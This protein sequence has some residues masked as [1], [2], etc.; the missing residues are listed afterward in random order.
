MDRIISLFDLIIATAVLVVVLVSSWVAM[1]LKVNTNK[2]RIRA[3]EQRVDAACND[4]D[5]IRVEVDRKAD[6]ILVGE[7]KQDLLRELG[8][9]ID[10]L[11]KVIEAI[12]KKNNIET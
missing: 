12:A 5:S 1:N 10:A 3:M 9:K 8:G 11:M 7:M 4:H 2:E 6:K